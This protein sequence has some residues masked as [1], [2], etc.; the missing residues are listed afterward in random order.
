MYDH[1]I[2]RRFV[3]GKTDCFGLVRDFYNENFSLGIPNY[4]RPA[5]WWDHG[6]NLYAD[7]FYDNG[8]RVVTDH[9][10]EWR[11]GDAVLMA[12]R[13]RVANHSGVFVETGKI[14][15]HFVGGLSRIDDYRGLWR[16]TTLMVLRHK[17]VNVARPRPQTLDL[18]EFVPD[19]LRRKLVAAVPQSRA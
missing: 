18:M 4:A 9:P 12:I 19:V 16:N 14:L 15:H 7:L 10:S 13:S 3:H 6:L 2:G 5:D 17:D 8:F 1:L 11:L